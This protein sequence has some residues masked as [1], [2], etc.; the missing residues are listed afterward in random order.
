MPRISVRLTDPQAQMLDGWASELVSTR[1]LIVRGLLERAIAV[2]S[3]PTPALSARA[4]REKACADEVA[5]LN[6][7]A[8]G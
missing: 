2:G 4:A 5:R 1:S 6:A 8:R 3:P 7:L